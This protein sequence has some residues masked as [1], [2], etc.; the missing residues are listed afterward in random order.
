MISGDVQFPQFVVERKCDIDQGPG[1]QE[2][3]QGRIVCQIPD[4][5]PFDNASMVVKDERRCVDVAVENSRYQGDKE[6]RGPWGG[7]SGF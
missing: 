4:G 6:E 3:L 5:A 2:L 7:E 1:A